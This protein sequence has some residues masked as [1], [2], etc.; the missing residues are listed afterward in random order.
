MVLTT[1]D[2]TTVGTGQRAEQPLLISPFS[3]PSAQL[4]PSS[5][6]SPADYEGPSTADARFLNASFAGVP[7]NRPLV[8]SAASWGFGRLPQTVDSREVKLF[9]VDIAR[10]PVPAA[11]VPSSLHVHS[12]QPAAVRIQL[13]STP[14]HLKL[15]CPPGRHGL[16]AQHIPSSAPPVS[17][18]LPSFV[19]WIGGLA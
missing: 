12:T 7:A 11:V 19:V 13:R 5:G 9:G 1:D 3:T 2:V 17:F 8:H 6:A 10:I 15:T 4:A 16:T 18:V 14:E